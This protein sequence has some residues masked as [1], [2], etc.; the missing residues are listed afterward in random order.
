VIDFDRIEL[1]NLSRSV[2]YRE[3]DIGKPKA[4]TAAQRLRLLNPDI[5]VTSIDG[6]LECDLGLGLIR[7]CDLV[8][9]CLDSIYARWALNRACWRAGTPWINA[10]MNATVGE[11]CLH[12]PGQGPCFE[13]GMTRQ[14]WQQIHERRSCM[15]LPRELPARTV[16][17]SAVIASLTA[18]LQVQEAL[19]WIHGEKHLSPGEMLLLSLQPYSLSSFTMA[20]RTECLAHDAY[21]PSIMLDAAPS[22]VTAAD[23]L[24]RV[25]DAVALQLDFDVL[26]SWHCRNCRE[27]PVGRRL[28]A[29][30]SAK[31][32]CPTCKADRTPQLVHQIGV[33]DW[34]SRQSL[35]SLGVPSRAI[36]RVI[37]RS[38]FEYVEL[39]A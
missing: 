18:A 21:G 16:P 24:M 1:P 34:L 29:A 25:P 14:M 31:L 10:G 36:M 9:G 7:E 8:L 13:C 3:E 11:V 27:E 39:I 22:E 4:S 28:S 38:G 32:A 30:L 19:A 26:E 15:L 12:V 6:D 23:L 35:A 17:G 5:Q 33:D 37:T 2:L 20:T